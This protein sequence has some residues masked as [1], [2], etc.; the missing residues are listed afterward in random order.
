MIKKA[1]M[2]ML[3]V[4]LTASLMV[5][6]NIH[7][8][9]AS[10]VEEKGRIGT[11]HWGSG[12]AE[13]SG[14]LNFGMGDI[15]WSIGNEERGY[16]YGSYYSNPAVY[17]ADRIENYWGSYDSYQGPQFVWEFTNANKHEWF[18]ESAITFA[19]ETSQYYS[20]ILLIRQSGL[21]GAVKPK[22]IHNGDLNHPRDYVLEYDWWYDD[23]GG[24]DFSILKPVATVS[25][26]PQ[27][28]DLWSDDEWITACIEL[29]KSCDVNDIDVSSIFLN[30]TVSA[31]RE[32]I[33]IGDYNNNMIP[34]LMVNLERDK[35][36]S[37]ILAEVNRRE[38]IEKRFMKIT[39][40]INGN[41]N[42]GT[43]FQGSNT[44]KI[45]PT[46]KLMLKGRMLVP[47]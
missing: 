47:V 5:T 18:T 23:S 12:V 7:P 9:T 21:Y 25:L 35:V 22:S 14:Y 44:V 27:E 41:F 42:D 37:F 24:S 10:Y 33:A 38:L 11:I 20:G 8:I 43:P 15:F 17:F 4:F 34:D 28:L 2:V 36:I 3:I 1:A 46:P 6:F 30:E 45:I 32:P 39:L 16:F 29:P 26:H 31:E 40:T 13:E 19:E